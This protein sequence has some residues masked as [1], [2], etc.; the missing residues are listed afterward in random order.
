MSRR[1]GRNQKRRMREELAAA[2]G[3]VLR[4]AGEARGLRYDLGSA[5]G[6]AEQAQH[7]VHELRR[8]I[9]D[10]A[11]AVGDQ[12]VLL[13]VPQKLVLDFGHVIGPSFHYDIQRPMPQLASYGEM[14]ATNIACHRYNEI[15]NVLECDVLLDHLSRQVHVEVSVGPYGM[16]RYAISNSALRYMSARSLASSIAQPLANHVAANLQALREKGAFRE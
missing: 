1:F 7:E 16:K 15:M 9:D 2:D 4:L 5:R 10:I 3:E 13:R 14:T 11:R 12:C 6:S 8:M